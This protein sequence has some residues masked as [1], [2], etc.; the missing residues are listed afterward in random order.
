MPASSASL[1]L[2][3]LSLPSLLA[4]SNPPPPALALSKAYLS[5]SNIQARFLRTAQSYPPSSGSPQ[6]TL[7]AQNNTPASPLPPALAGGDGGS[8]DAAGRYTLF[9]PSQW[10]SGF[11]SQGV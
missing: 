8:G 7:G 6:Y 9:E 1:S 11:F 3:L 2:L 5:T 4:A 10:T